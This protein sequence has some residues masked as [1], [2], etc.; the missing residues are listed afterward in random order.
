VW[1]IGTII[2]IVVGC[3]AG[4]ALL[5]TIIVIVCIISKRNKRARIVAMQ[6]QQPAVMQPSFISGQGQQQ[7]PYNTYQYP[8]PGAPMNNFNL[9]YPPPYS[10]TQPVGIKI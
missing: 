8:P 4:L 1:S 6:A 10:S 5:V 9:Q 7:F 3:L 2:G